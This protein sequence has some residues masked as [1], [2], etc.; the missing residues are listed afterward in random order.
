MKRK[1]NPQRKTESLPNLH[2]AIPRQH[3]KLK[4]TYFRVPFWR[5]GSVFETGRE[6]HF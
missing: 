4:M 2:L 1:S 6:L 5:N 3:I